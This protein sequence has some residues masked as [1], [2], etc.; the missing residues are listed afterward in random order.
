MPGPEGH[1]AET[2]CNLFAVQQRRH[3]KRR[4]PQVLDVASND[5][6][7]A[8]DD[9]LSIEQAHVAEGRF[10]ERR[11][12]VRRAVKIVQGMDVRDQTPMGLIQARSNQP[13]EFPSPQVQRDAVAIVGIQNNC[14]VGMCRAEE[15]FL[16]VRDVAV[17]GIRKPKIA[18]GYL[19]RSPV[20]VDDRH[21]DAGLGEHRAE[22]AAAASDHQD[23]PR[24]RLPEQAVDGVDV[25]SQAYA[26]AIRLGLKTASLDIEE[27][28]PGTV[29]QN[30]DVAEFT[31]EFCDSDHA[32]LFDGFAALT[33][34]SENVLRR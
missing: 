7:I 9:T 20:L 1:P 28:F 2:C 5:Q 21:L 32:S 26:V 4:V 11:I 24:S 19:E 3:E 6:R 16:A 22:A 14:I 17:D 31:F 12:P 29:F 25:G 33:A 10:R 15:E 18:A 23:V 34:T 13:E 30:F 8:S 27:Q